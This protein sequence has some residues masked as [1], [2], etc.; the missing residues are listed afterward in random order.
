MSDDVRRAA[1][2]ILA[3]VV[4]IRDSNG[5]VVIQS[6]CWLWARE[7]AQA[8]L[9]QQREDTTKG[10]YVGCTIVAEGEDGS[11]LLQSKT[12]ARRRIWNGVD[13]QQREE[14]AGRKLY[15]DVVARLRSVEELLARGKGEWPKN[16]YVRDET[17][18]TWQG[19]RLALRS[20]LQSSGFLKCDSDGRD[21]LHPYSP[22]ARSAGD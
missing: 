15:E 5:E 9:A 16:D 13:D 12:G 14:D 22:P 8:Y 10:G 21:V 18:A 17:W 1:E 2:N 7:V 3:T 6:R 4:S 19:E 20:V 11:L